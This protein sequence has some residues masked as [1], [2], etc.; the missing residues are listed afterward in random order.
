MPDTTLIMWASSLMWSTIMFSRSKAIVLA[1]HI[2]LSNLIIIPSISLVCIEVFARWWPCYNVKK[3]AVTVKL[4]YS[5]DIFGRLISLELSNVLITLW[6]AFAAGDFNILNKQNHWWP[7]IDML[8]HCMSD[9][10]GHL[11]F[12]TCV[13]KSKMFCQVFFFSFLG[14]CVA[15]TFY[16]SVLSETQVMKSD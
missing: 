9:Y 15:K 8:I 7:C 10:L 12:L 2:H 11:F 1:N 4:S 3:K 16:S 5:R 6:L 13:L 14:L